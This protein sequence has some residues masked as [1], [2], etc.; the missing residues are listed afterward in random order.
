MTTTRS[1]AANGLT[2]AVDAAG[3]GPDIALCL[4]GFPESRFSWR[5]QLPLLADLGWHA[6]APD[7]RGYGG[8]SRPPRRADYHIDHLVADVAALFAALATE[9]GKGRHLLVAHDW[10]AI[11]AW[12]YA[13]RNPGVLDGLIIMNVPHPRVFRDVLKTSWAQ[14]KK[15]WYVAFF[16]LPWLPEALL[17]AR[18]AE[19]IGKA[20]SDMA[21]DKSAFPP[22]VTD[23]Y[24]A[25]A[26]QPGALTAMVNYYRANFPNILAEPVVPLAV[27]TLLLWGEEDSALDIA[28]TEGY[29]PLV[30]DFTLQRFPGVSHWVQQEAPV[31]VNAAMR[32]WLGAKLG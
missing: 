23:H 6:V 19:A 26:R 8:S 25:N 14:K 3:A 31:A 12:I 29:G 22:A 27:P 4:H 13:L 2:F 32:E 9:H 16:Q 18:G 10:G 7:L 20:F 1:I 30:A 21:I 11:I 17:G 24:R 28:L 15:S 5:H